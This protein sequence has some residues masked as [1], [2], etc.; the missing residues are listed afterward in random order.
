M[1]CKEQ[2]KHIP[3]MKENKTINKTVLRNGIK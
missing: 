1:F 2:T 3:G